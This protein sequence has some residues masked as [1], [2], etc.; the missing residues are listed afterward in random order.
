ME[1]KLDPDQR[2]EGSTP[3]FQLTTFAQEHVWIG[4]FTIHSNCDRTS[5]SADSDKHSS[6]G[7]HVGHTEA[8]DFVTSASTQG[9]SAQII[10]PREAKAPQ[11]TTR[12]PLKGS[13]CHYN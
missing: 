5:D 7:P 13:V 12:A 9:P 6:E 3:R 1:A 8:K 11:T 4:A 2:R 10:L